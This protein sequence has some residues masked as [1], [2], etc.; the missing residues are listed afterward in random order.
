[1]SSTPDTAASTTTT[2]GRGGRNNRRRANQAARTGS[3]TTT[4]TAT[5]RTGFRGD[6]AEMNG[7][8]FECYEEQNDRRQY[9]KTVQALDAYAKQ[10]MEYASNLAPLFAKEPTQ[11]VVA[12]PADVAAGEE[13]VS[14]L[15][16]LI[17][18][19]KI[20]QYVAKE[21][22]LESNLTSLHSVIWGQCSDEMKARVK[23]LADYKAK[24]VDNDCVW[25][26]LQIRLITLRFDERMDGFMSIMDAHRS[27]LT[28]VQ[29]PGQTV[30][31]YADTLTGWANTIK[32]HGGTVMYNYKLIPEKESTDSPA[33]S[34]EDRQKLAYQRTLASALINGADPSRYGTLVTD[35]RNQYAK[36]KDEY[37][38][39]IVAAQNLLVIYKTPANALTPRNGGNPRNP[40]AASPEASALTFAQRGGAATVTRPTTPI[41]AGPPVPGSDGRTLAD[42]D[43]FTCR[44][45][46]HHAGECPAT[47]AVSGTTLAQ[48]AYMLAQAGGDPSIDPNWILLDSQSTLS[49]FKNPDMLTNIR[50]SPHV[51]RALTN[52]GHQ[53]STM[54]GNFPNLGEVWYNTKLIAN[55]LSLAAVRKVCRVTMDSLRE[56]TMFVHRLDSSLMKFVEH[57]SGLYVYKPNDTNA[58]A[59]G[60]TM[61]STVAA[62]QKLFS[63][64]AVQAADV[65]RDLYRLL[66]RPDEKEFYD[67]LKKNMIRNCPVTPDDAQRAL[68]VYGPDIAVVKG[69]TTRH[70]AA[71]RVPTFVSKPIPAPILEHHR[72]ITL[73]VD[74]FFV[75]G[76]AFFHT[77][78]RHIGFCTVHPVADRTRGTILSHLKKVLHLYQARG[79]RVRDIHADSELE[80][81]RD[82]VLP[83]ALNIVPADS[84]VG[85]VERSIRTIK[86]RLRSCA[87]SPPFKC[88]PR[89]LLNHMVADAVRCLNQFPWK[90]GISD[91]MSPATIVTGVGTPAYDSM[92]IEF[93]S[94]AQ[95]FED[96][97]PSNTLRARSLGAIA[98]TPAGNAQGD[99]YFMSLATGHKVSRHTWTPLPMT[100]T[101]IARVEALAL[102]EGQPMLQDR[103]LVVD[104]RHDQPIDHTEYDRD[105]VPPDREADVFLVAD[106][107]AVDPDEI[108][109]L[110]ADG[111]HP[112]YDPPAVGAAQG[113]N[114]DVDLNPA[115]FLEIDVNGA[116]SDKEPDDD[117]DYVDGANEDAYDNDD[118]GEAADQ[119]AQQHSSR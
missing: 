43:C 75:Q 55:I 10:N 118:H 19:E 17:F 76:L 79:L 50:Q 105:Y 14:E 98:L 117:D 12:L 91:T 54:V 59:T 112:Y 5:A 29:A 74:F 52:G 22:A 56:P 96:N 119:G 102:H 94:Y 100:D 60:Y 57:A 23:T 71:P 41:V 20:K 46:G 67:I 104:W 36:G 95:V 45:Y 40:V 33:R 89:L 53:D 113:A 85:E 108:G 86:E 66:G 7:N 69:K 58:T 115:Q 25:L 51:I 24:A 48:F 78:S 70:T 93:G 82:A 1:M 84:H 62:Q 63:R 97:N 83:I 87:H 81:V 106:Y 68:V 32:T 9:A 18:H 4:T 15:R 42:I 77:I 31:E 8:V 103:G 64:R 2:S 72:D 80:C 37:P 16:R 107:D 116:D 109:D 28:C 61:V 110:L 65:A 3:T 73:C 49:V 11:P 92:R 26:L 88:L 38:K 39:D 114:V 101:A 90:N 34:V 47:P 44:R 99:Y 111:P 13:G 35:L 6:T 30:E 21:E 27:F